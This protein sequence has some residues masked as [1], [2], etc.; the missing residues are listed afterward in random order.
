MLFFVANASALTGRGNN[1]WLLDGA[2][3]ALI[4]AGLGDRAHLDAIARA[5]G[6]RPL[7]R[8]LV[9]HGHPDHAAGVPA[10][11]ARWPSCEAMKFPLPGE[12]G[13]TPLADG[14]R[15][16]AGDT[17]LVVLHTPGHAP[18]HVCFWEPEDQVLYAGDMVAI[19]TTIMIP[20]GRGGN[21]RDY[22]ASLERLAAL[23]PLRIY[24]G[25]GPVIERPVEL[26]REYIEHRLMRD[27]QIADCL[28][29][30]ITDVDDIVRRIYPS[31]DLALHPAARATVEAHLHSRGTGLFSTVSADLGTGLPKDSRSRERADDSGSLLRP[32]PK[33]NETVENR[34]VPPLCT[35][36][37]D[38]LVID[39]RPAE[40]FA[41]G[42]IPGA[43]HL[44]LWGLSLIDTSEAPLRAFMWMIGHLF[45][46]R[47]VSPTR[48]VVVYEQDSGMRAARAYWFLDYL[49]HP[50]ARVLDG[51]FKAWIAAGRPVTTDVTTPVP[52][53]W[54]GSPD[55]A[56]IA[57][58]RDVA[59]RLGRPETAILDT[60]SDAEYYAEAVRAKRGG[61]IPGAVHLEWT[62]NLTS[63]GRFK[64][65]E[66]LR[67]MYSGAGI[68]PDREVVTYCQGGYRAAHAYLALK[69]AGYPDVRNYT[70]SWKEWGD[71][72]DLPLERTS[73]R[74]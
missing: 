22:L 30:G 56:R 71:R 67:A 8:V 23:S 24:P 62:N 21:L 1:T 32:V 27:R 39:L 74:G 11:R 10:I 52:T 50:D 69:I 46:L 15:V 34:P 19:G 57:T 9:T 2:E 45:A 73:R 66:E 25:H 48:P 42:H 61:A 41:V 49:G 64:T 36:V 60:R 70:G 6:G 54:H 63:D 5:L 29:D 7:A 72:E 51:G 35:D 17:E 16:R 14:D 33:Y 44:D 31:L 26:I 58:W 28:A 40:Q 47:G 38:A 13:W 4:D 12:S 43:V 59:D 20:A 55:P 53:D 3:P 37:G 68:T 65:A 18:D